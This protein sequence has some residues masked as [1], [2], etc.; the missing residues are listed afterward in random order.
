MKNPFHCNIRVMYLKYELKLH[1]ACVDFFF[2]I[3]SECF[4]EDLIAF[5]D[6]QFKDLI[7]QGDVV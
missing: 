4:W 5:P 3:Y 1:M 6:C 7:N 2:C